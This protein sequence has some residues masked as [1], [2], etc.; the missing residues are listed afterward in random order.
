VELIKFRELKGYLPAVLAIHMD[1]DQE[2][3][4]SAEL[5]IVQEHLHTAV[6]MAHEEM[7]LAV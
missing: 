7:L 5:E 2:T 6:T 4:I 3:E 1:A